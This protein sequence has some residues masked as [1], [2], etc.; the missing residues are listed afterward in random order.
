[1]DNSANVVAVGI[2]RSAI[3]ALLTIVLAITVITVQSPSL[4]QTK[5]SREL[6]IIP[7]N[8]DTD[9]KFYQATFSF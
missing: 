4:G 2:S 1:V 6:A 7:P 5:P 3:G 8:K 9:L